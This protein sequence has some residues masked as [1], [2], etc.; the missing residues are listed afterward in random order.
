MKSQ[1]ELIAYYTKNLDKVI[2]AY[3]LVSDY[4]THAFFLLQGAKMNIPFAYIH[5]WA[6]IKCDQL[7]EEALEFTV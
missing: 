3:G 7:Q 2:N 6:K 5:A 1:N 4:T